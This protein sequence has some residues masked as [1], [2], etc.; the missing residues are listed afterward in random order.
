[1]KIAVAMPSRG[2]VHSR[3]IPAV[4]DNLAGHD[5]A[6]WFLS[7][8]LPIPECAQDVVRRALDAGADAVWFV[9]EDVVPPAGALAAS[10]ALLADG[11]AVAAVD[12]PTRQGVGCLS[13]DAAG[14]IDWVGLGCTLISRRA[15]DAVGQPWFRVERG[16][17]GHDIWFCRAVRRAGLSIGQ[18]PK[19]VAGHV[20]LDAPG[21]LGTNVGFHS[22]TVLDRIDRPYSEAAAPAVERVQLEPPGCVVLVP[23]RAD[24]GERDRLWAFCRDWWET[25]VDVPI[26]EGIHEASEGLFNRSLA[27]NRAAAAAGDWSVAIIMDSDTLPDL[28]QLKIATGHAYESGQMV[29]PFDDRRELAADETERVLHGE[30]LGPRHGKPFGAKAVSGAVVVSRRMWDVVGGFDAGFVGWGAEDND[31]ADACERTGG[32]MVQ[33]PGPLWHL[34]HQRSA[35]ATLDSP[36]HMANKRRWLE[37]RREWSN[38]PA[39]YANRPMP[40]GSMTADRIP[41]ILHRVVLGLEPE[42]ARH[43]WKLF[44]EMHPDWDLVTHRLPL[45]PKEWPLTSW[46]FPHA[47][48]PAQLSDFVRLEALWRDG[49]VYIDWDIE[50]VR[51]LDPLLELEGFAGWAHESLVGTGVLGFRPHHPA[52]AKA[53]E[54]A[55]ERLLRDRTNLTA[56]GCGA[57]TDAV[58]GRSDV[59]VLPPTAFYPAG[60]VANP[61]QTEGGY[62]GDPWVFAAHWGA[63]SWHKEFPWKP[64][65]EGKLPL[66]TREAAQLR[67]EH[68]RQRRE[69]RRTVWTGA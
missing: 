59:L 51:P 69:G 32:K 48:H 22:V 56:C 3:T 1:M 36:V 31:F 8:D 2:L 17:G 23:R 49:G 9:E 66:R 24:G 43:W 53:L 12:Y 47:A 55:S 63:G 20:R 60:H 68:A 45:D 67:R 27:L 18:V 13:L 46:M 39:A 14:A 15:F 50:P 33:I 65:H 11:Y 52:I 16:Y 26:V 29:V 54:L 6:G 62:A 61:K 28:E 5:F 30:P 38:V 64:Q 21:K 58:R 4:M 7:H 41:A 40:E 10:L 35:D 19:M 25:H 34:Y 57:M 37:H 44:D 42:S